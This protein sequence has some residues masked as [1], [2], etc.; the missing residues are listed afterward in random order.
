MAIYSS[1]STIDDA[2]YVRIF[3][4]PR[5]LLP[6]FVSVNP[7]MLNTVD[8]PVSAENSVNINKRNLP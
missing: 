8:P 7:D 5:A 3:G 1:N 4:A 2:E 6:N